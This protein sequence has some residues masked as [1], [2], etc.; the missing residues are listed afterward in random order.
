MLGFAPAMLNI[1]NNNDGWIE[2]DDDEEMEAEEDDEEEMEIE[3]ND[4]ENDAEIIHPYEEADPLN[5]PPPSPEI[6]EQEFM[7][8]PVG[9]GSSATIFNP[10]LCRVYPP[11]PMGND[12]N[13]LHSRVKT[14]T[15]QMRDMYRVE[16]SSFKRLK[17]NDMRMD[18]FDDDLTER[19]LRAE[20]EM[21]RIRLR[22]AE[23][24]HMDAEYYK[25]H[26]AHMSWL[27]DDL[28]KWGDVVAVVPTR[29]DNEN[30]AVPSDP[31]LPQLRGSPPIA[32]ERE[33]V[34]NEGPAQGPAAAPPARERMV[35]SISHYAEKNKVMFDAATFQGRAL[36]WWNSQ[37]ATLGLEVAN[38]KSWT[39]MKTMMIEELCPPEEIQMIE[40]E[41]W[42]LKVKDYDI[43]AYTAHFNKLVLLCPEMVL[44]EKKNIGAYIHGLSDNIKGEV[45]S[46]EPTTLNAAVRMAHT[47]MEQ[48]R[49]AKAERD[50]EGKKRK[51]ENFQSGGIDHLFNIDLMPIELGTFD[52][53]VGMDWLVE[54]DAIIVCGKKEVHVPYKNKTLVVKGDRGP[55]RLKVISCIKARKY[56]ERELSDQLK[57][58]SE[59]G[60]IRLSSLPWGDPVLFVKK[61]DS[62]FRMYIDYRELNKL[63]VKNRYPLPRIDDLFD[64][65]K[66]SSM[67]SK[68]DLRSGYHQLRIQEEDIPL[69]AFKTRKEKLYAKFSKCDFWLDSVK[70]LGHVIDSEGVLV[71]PAKIEAIKNWA[72][73]TMPTEICYHP[74]KANVVADAL[75][76]KERERSL[77]VRALVMSAYTNLS[78]RVLR[79]QTEAMKKENVKAENLGRL[80][81]PI[82]E[83]RSDGIRYFH[84]RLWLSLFNGLRDLIMHES[85][86]SK[87]SIHRGSNKMY[88]DFKKCYW[89]PNMK[90]DIATYVSKC[91]T[92]AKVKVEHQ[93]PSGLLQQPKIPEW[94]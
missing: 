35:F 79:A 48:K 42:N 43:T 27:Y 36:N 17:R 22:A 73:T 61:K 86:K 52:V 13:T 88:Q 69:T 82:F 84:K 90:A 44:A 39:E 71:D 76:R 66:G 80:L 83:F 23:D 47:L 89:W 54:R 34:R 93:K 24:K 29:E 8:A 15:K 20:N 75:S 45:S 53:L 5:R 37:V 55:S 51:W 26:L 78:E 64:Q 21:L 25:Y 81:K 77:R 1:P 62:S 41:L 87:Y 67:Y 19:D 16:S 14:L 91:L 40:S 32:T 57:E 18:S 58:L 50:A 12:L 68:I 4:D 59:K 46:S 85:H 92:C 74:D 72:E 63:T 60:F 2:E 56:V 7:N 3:D 31:Q 6:A 49:L 11:R 38:G 70:F 65:L 33:R 28:S 94:K 10:A 30:P 9:E